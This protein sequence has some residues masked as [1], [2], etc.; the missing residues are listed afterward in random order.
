MARA[1]NTT[2][3]PQVIPVQAAFDSVAPINVTVLENLAAVAGGKCWAASPQPAAAA[4]GS[5]K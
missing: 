4:E 5:L 1:R 2:A 3:K